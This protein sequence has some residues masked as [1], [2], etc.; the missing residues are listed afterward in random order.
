[1]SKTSVIYNIFGRIV[2]I[3]ST[4]NTSILALALKNDW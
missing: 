2:V 1:M 4:A 3:E